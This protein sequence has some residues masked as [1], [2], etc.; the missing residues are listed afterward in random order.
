LGGI[1]LFGAQ[2]IP[3]DDPDLRAANV[4][5]SIPNYACCEIVKASSTLSAANAILDKLI[6]EHHIKDI[7]YPQ[8]FYPITQNISE[9]NIHSKAEFLCTE[10]NYPIALASRINQKETTEQCSTVC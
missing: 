7:Q 4:A 10:R 2:Q 5:F 9:T 8:T 6:L 1:P 3:G